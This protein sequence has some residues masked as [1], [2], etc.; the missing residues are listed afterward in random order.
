MKTQKKKVKI[1]VKSRTL[2]LRTTCQ[3]TCQKPSNCH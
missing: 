3:N 1:A 2:A